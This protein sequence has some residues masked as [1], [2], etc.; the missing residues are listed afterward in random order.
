MTRACLFAGLIACACACLPDRLTSDQIA[1]K[2]AAAPKDAASADAEP[3]DTAVAVGCGNGVV[4]DKE[5]CDLKPAGICSGCVKCERRNVWK[6]DGDYAAVVA[7]NALSNPKNIDKLTADSKTGFSVEFW[8]STAKYPAAN[9]A[10][11]VVALALPADNSK[12]PAM[13]VGVARDGDKNVMF[14]TCAYTYQQALQSTVVAAQAVD[15]ILPDTWHHLRC[16]FSA[17]TNKLLLSVDG[18][19]VRESATAVAKILGKSLFDPG[20]WLLVGAVPFNKDKPKDHFLGKVDELRIAS[21]AAAD[22]F[23][24][25]KYRYDGTELGTQLL[26]HFDFAADDTVVPDASA[27]GYAA[28]Q[29]FNDGG[30]AKFGSHGLAVGPDDCYGF[31]PEQANCKSAAPWCEGQ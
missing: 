17:K 18:G 30:T 31:P 19:V 29:V 12:S 20:T 4:E 15:P 26:Y 21:G 23:K 14:P 24:M 2:I 11:V 22:D 1:A 16:A 6:V 9:G 27:N 25:F 10:D 8:F 28:Q 7:P 5:Q 13:V 3:A